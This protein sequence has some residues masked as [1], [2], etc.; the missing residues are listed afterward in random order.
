MIFFC[1]IFISATSRSVIVLFEFLQKS[2]K[3]LQEVFCM[4]QQAKCGQFLSM[5]LCGIY[6]STLAWMDVWP[7]TYWSV[8][9]L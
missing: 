7:K 9:P 2:V 1:I 4:I 3:V 5:Y 6:C 8:F